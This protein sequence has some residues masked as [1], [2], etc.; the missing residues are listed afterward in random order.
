MA[1][2]DYGKLLTIIKVN[3]ELR[4]IWL[5]YS[6]S[7]FG[8]QSDK[9]HILSTLIVSPVFLYLASLDRLAKPQKLS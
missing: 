2:S 4:L 3:T 1:E 5:S 7:S 6:N 9:N 8:D